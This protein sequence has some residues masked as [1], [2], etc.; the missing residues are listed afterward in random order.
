MLIQV[1]LSLLR[2]SKSETQHLREWAE[3]IAIRRGKKIAVVALAR[4][5]AGIL[6]AMMRDGTQYRPPQAQEEEKEAA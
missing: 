4:G 3:T 2:G 5:L 6:F 1:A